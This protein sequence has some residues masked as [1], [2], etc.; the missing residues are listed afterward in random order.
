MNHFVSWIKK[1][2]STI[3]VSVFL[4]IYAIKEGLFNAGSED[5]RIFLGAAE[6]MSQKS[7]LYFVYFKTGKGFAMPYAYT[8]F[9]AMVLIPFLY[10]FSIKNIVFLWMILNI[11]FIN[12]TL[13]ILSRIFNFQSKHKPAL[14]VFLLSLRFVL[15]NYDMA[16][17]TIFW[18]YLMA[19]AYYQI[20]Y[21][22]KSMISSALIALGVSIKILPI[23]MCFYFLIR[24]KYS[25]ILWVLF[26]TIIYTALPYLFFP[27]SYL[28]I[29]FM[30][31]WKTINPL[32]EG[33][34]YQLFD[35]AT[36]SIPSLVSNYNDYFGNMLNHTQTFLVILLFVFFW[37]VSVYLI[38]IKSN[39][40]VYKNEVLFSLTV[41]S[42]T[43]LLPHQ[44]HYSFF[45]AIALYALWYYWLCEEKIYSKIALGFFMLST[46]FM[47]FTSDLFVGN[48]LKS[49]FKSYGLI[50][51]GGVLLLISVF[52]NICHLKNTGVKTQNLQLTKL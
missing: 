37:L 19:E 18:V 31:C 50:G 15:H 30:D 33:F 11:V 46:L 25:A 20:E 8:P 5:F 48:E 36:Q 6:A 10:I 27:T 9:F 24:K 42:A 3:I 1:H 22:E 35:R 52:I 7:N 29:Q 32:Q 26:F 51:L 13:S 39:A 2:W 40:L 45:S 44:Q 43:M 21:K 49:I 41:F 4:I 38:Y 12:R 14:I 23:L 34:T 47:T 28:N 17:V 16:Q